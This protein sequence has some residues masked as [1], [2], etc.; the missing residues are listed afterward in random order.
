[1]ENHKF[2]IEYFKDL[3]L[4]ATAIGERLNSNKH[5]LR[6]EIKAV[7]FH[8]LQIKQV[9]DSWEAKIVFDI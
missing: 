3:E 7:T 9:G 4:S 8:D 6:A 2:E 1:L 5:P